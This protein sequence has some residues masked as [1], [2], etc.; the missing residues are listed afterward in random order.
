MN[1]NYDD[2]DTGS[3]TTMAVPDVLPILPLE[4]FVIF[5]HSNARMV[6]PPHH[7]EI[8]QDASN[9]NQ[10]IGVTANLGVDETNPDTPPPSTVGT[11][12]RIGDFTPMP[13]G[14]TLVQVK[15]LVRIRLLETVSDKPYLTARVE[16]ARETIADEVEAEALRRRLISQFSEVIELSDSIPNEVKDVVGRITSPLKLAYLLASNL[17]MDLEQRQ[18][19]LRYDLIEDKMKV[20]TALLRKELEILSINKTIDEQVQEKMTKK[21][22]EYHLRQKLEAIRTELGEDEATSS[23]I[24]EYQERIDAS[25]MSAEARKEAE[26]ELKRLSG[27]SPQSA[28]YP[29][30][31]NYLDWLLDMPWELPEETDIDIKEARSALDGD[32]FGLSDVK[33]R[34][35][36]YLAVRQV[37][38]QRHANAQGEGAGGYAKGLI[39]C[40][41]GPPGTGKTSLGKSIAAAMGRKFTRMSLGGIHDESEIRGH[42]RT[43]IGAMPGRI[44]QA[45]KRAESRN[46]VFMLDEID[47]T[48]KDWRGDP[49]SALLEVLDPEQNSAFRDHYLDVDFDLSEVLF[50]ATANQMDTIPPALLDRMDVIQLEGYTE[51]EKFQIAKNHLVPRQMKD[52]GLDEQEVTFMDEAIYKIIQDYTGEAGVR[53]LERHIGTICRKGVL[54]LNENK[55][56]SIVVTAE[57]VK[58]FLKKEKFQ[59]E[60]AEDT[61][62]PG[63]ATGLAV[64][65]VGGE[66][67]Y[68][69]ATRMPGKGRLTLTG[70]LGDVMKE[71]AQ[72]AQSYVRSRAE[73]LDIAPET[74]DTTDIHLHIPAGALPKDGPSAG[75]IMTLAMASAYTGIAIPGHIGATGE[76]TLRGRV[77]PVGGIKMKVLA[78]HRAG[79]SRIIIPERNRKDVD[80]LPVEVRSALNLEMVETMDAVFE[81]IFTNRSETPERGIDPEACVTGNCDGETLAVHPSL[82]AQGERQ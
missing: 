66:I 42:R 4:G 63:I 21:Q 71:S 26:R 8:L 81:L 57:Q 38:R 15:G 34:I 49:S 60:K 65:S 64:T 54:A 37:T 16:P 24:E 80:E 19:I 69:E 67:L 28:E 75:V 12:V 18:N 61:G 10:F 77:L 78:A 79:L 1:T 32:H 7:K 2:G 50:I 76:I 13:D 11:M 44:V 30:I 41:V 45:V 51:H 62:M 59:H 9:A 14:N 35:L 82:E 74:F 33:E 25:A 55:W 40:L 5:P 53:S 17:Q 72:I 6:I 20:L 52:H 43:Y 46:P 39:M 56:H 29:V 73:K 22:R 3:K 70:Q 23:P 68:I 58:T 47:K 27:L 36:E 31:Q 48:G